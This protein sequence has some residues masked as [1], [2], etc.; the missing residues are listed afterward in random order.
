MNMGN[1]DEYNSKR[2]FGKTPEPAGHRAEPEE[3]NRFVVQ[4]HLARR[5]HYDFR[6]QLGM[7]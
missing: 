2:D 4:R 7:C 5:E 6:L 3:K 1:L